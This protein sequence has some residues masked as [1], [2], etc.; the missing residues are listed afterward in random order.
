MRAAPG[1]VVVDEA[2]SPFTDTSFLP[3]A[4]E[5]DNLL[6]MRTF[7]KMGLAGLRLGWIAGPRHW[8][9]ELDKVRLPYN[10]NRLTQT[11]AHLALE[12]LDLFEHQTRAIRAERARLY[13]ELGHRPDLRV[14]PSEANFL[15]F[16][17]PDGPALFQGLRDQGVLVKNLHGA[18]PALHHC[19]RVTIGTPEENGTFLEALD[20]CL[21]AP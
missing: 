10:I 11:A 9:A 7:S 20:R 18:H 3:R 6:V 2:Y 15:L 1:V 19:L 12:H 4:G 21:T 8:I 13:R 14:W 17:A 5:F 16:R